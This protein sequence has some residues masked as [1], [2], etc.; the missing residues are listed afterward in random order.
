[1]AAYNENLAKAMHVKCM[2]EK[3]E[4][5]MKFFSNEHDL[6]SM[7]LMEDICASLEMQYDNLINGY[8]N[9]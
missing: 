4:S 5:L 2:L 1:M 3:A 7:E 6:H 8:D 9:E